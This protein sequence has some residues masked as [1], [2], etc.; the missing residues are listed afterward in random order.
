MKK[1]TILLAGFLFLGILAQ[2]VLPTLN[3]LSKAYFDTGAPPNVV[4]V[5]DPTYCLPTILT[6]D[7]T[8]DILL[9]YSGQS[10][11]VFVVRIYGLDKE[12][13]VNNLTVVTP[14]PNTVLIKVSLPSDI[15][16]G[17]Y[18]ILVETT[19]DGIEYRVI[20]P[21]SLWIVEEYPTSLKIMHISDIHIGISMDNWRASDR[22]ERYIAVANSL[23]PDILVITGDI[24]DVG[25]DIYSYRV[26]MMLT[27]KFL[28]PTFCVPGNHDWSQVSSLSD[29]YRLYGTFV[30]PRYWVRDLGN[31]VLVGLDTGYGGILDMEQ[32]VWLNNTLS[33]YNESGKK[34]LILMHHPLFTGFGILTGNSSNYQP[35]L[36][37][38]Y[39]SWE[40]NLD[41]ALTFLRI[42]DSYPNIMG[43]F[44]GHIHADST[45]LYAY[46]T[47]FLTVTTANG[48]TSQYRG[49]RLY[50]VHANG[51]LKV[52]NYGAS[53]YSE[54][55][56]YPADG[57]NIKVIT[58]SN[59]TLYANVIWTS[60]PLPFITD[61]FTL[62]FYL[63]KSVDMPSYRLYARYNTTD[64]SYEYLTYGDLWLVRSNVP[65]KPN[66][67]LYLIFSSYPDETPPS[68]RITYYSPTKPISG[69]SVVTVYIAATDTGW[70]LDTVK[71][72]YRKAGDY[73]WSEVGVQESQGTYI[74]Q[75]PQLQTNQVV[76]KAV[77]IDLAGHVSE[78]PEVLI[79]YIEATPTTTPTTTVTTPATTPTTS[80]TTTTPATLT[81]SPTASP[82]TPAT[83]PV[84]TP[85]TTQT[86]AGLVSGDTLIMLVVLGI[87]A[88][89]II[90]VVIKFVRKV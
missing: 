21:R 55:A 14:A 9:E 87:A 85:T 42:I 68:V 80:P 52:I 46:R 24:A 8:L 3:N 58:N 20:S 34:I 89:A 43:V 22:Y 50:Q 25:S 13:E 65:L 74:A 48:G 56:S 82:T 76:V 16:P 49:Y 53:T 86:I 30:G 28:R 1:L 63:N 64:V 17:L 2:L 23:E 38:M 19:V 31:F 4:R 51:T 35:L 81:T 7:S 57:L 44:S 73:E 69:K 36:G 26:F 15:E 18:T 61:N 5:K 37:P 60:S 90:L 32:L 88:L 40:G 78:T 45:L 12:Y 27:N 41:I 39:A 83:T 75:I 10:I 67:K 6:K 54:N 66:M 11:Q 62:Y 72:L 79:D 71:L 77:A 59:F 29:F 84:T 70:G 47:W 33:S